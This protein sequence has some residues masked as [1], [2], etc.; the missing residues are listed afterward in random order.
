[1]AK[2]GY[3][4]MKYGMKYE[5]AVK[6]Y[7]KYVGNWG[8]EATVWRLI[9]VKDGIVAATY[10]CSPGSRLH[11]EVIPSH[12]ALREGETYDMASVRIRILD[13]N[14]N[15][16][17]YAQLPVRLSLEGDAQ[18]V[19]PGVVTAEGGM[20]GTYIKSA[21]KTGEARLTISTDQTEDVTLIFKIS[22]Q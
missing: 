4:M 14:G 9:A 15:V 21:G 5:D 10:T 6:L 8:G 18:L 1:M 17:P 20:T 3:A 13:E 7:G 22:A 12:T 19:G 16:A 11:L 2:M